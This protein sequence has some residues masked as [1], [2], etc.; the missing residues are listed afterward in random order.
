MASSTG[1]WAWIGLTSE[2]NLAC[3]HCY[4]PEELAG[5]YALS[6][7]RIT[8]FLDDHPSVEEVRLGIGEAMLHPA[9]PDVLDLLAERG[10]R[11]RLA[12]NGT[13]LLVLDSDYLERLAAVEVPVD[14]DN[15]RQMNELRGPGSFRRS[16]RAIERCV[17]LGLAVTVTTAMTSLNYGRIDHIA[18]FAARLGATHRVTVYPPVH[19]TDLMPEWGQMWEGIRRLLDGGELLSCSEGVVL[20]ALAA[21]MGA[22]SVRP[23]SARCAHDA[24]SLLPD[25]RQAGCP[26]AVGPHAEGSDPPDGLP[27]KCAAC[28]FG[29]LC[30][31][32]CRARRLLTD[33]LD[34]PDPYCPLRDG[35]RVQLTAQWS[36]GAAPV[37]AA[38]CGVWVDAR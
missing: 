30:G 10:I 37:S 1:R 15:P 29:A 6:L 25:G 16:V 31:G 11:T 4:R 24:V 2:C 32:G 17:D 38:P 20:A 36:N 35:H 22:G 33:G 23:S 8:A 5:E 9:L 18:N 21:G 12:S 3:A 28:P 13:T 27:A 19:R 14:S 26:Y 34:A 7:E